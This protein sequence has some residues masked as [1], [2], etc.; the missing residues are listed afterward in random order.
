MSLDVYKTFLTRKACCLTIIYLGLP[1]RLTLL[2]MFV[3]LD[4]F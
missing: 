4:V 1:S 3:Y 2:S